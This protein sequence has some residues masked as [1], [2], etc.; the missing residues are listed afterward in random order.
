[1]GVWV[2]SLSTCYVPHSSFLAP[3]SWSAA[4][5][6]FANICLTRFL[7][8]LLLQYFD[9]LHDNFVE[10]SCFQVTYSIQDDAHIGGK[11]AV[12]TN[13]APLLQ[14]TFGK[15]IFIELDRVLVLD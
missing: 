4:P 12:R 8:H 5:F 11:D 7:C 13:I 2:I 10:L 3:S 15:V 6:L 9:Y 14:A 1:M